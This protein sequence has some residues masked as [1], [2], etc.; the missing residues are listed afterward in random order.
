MADASA[1]LGARGQARRGALS[2]ALV[3]V[4]AAPPP[5]PWLVADARLAE[6]P[7]PTIELEDGTARMLSL[8]DCPPA[9]LFGRALESVVPTDERSVVALAGRLGVLFRPRDAFD[10][11][12]VR[13]ADSARLAWQLQAAFGLA[14]A[15]AFFAQEGAAASEL[16]DYVRSRPWGMGPGPIPFVGLL[17]WSSSA[18]RMRRAANKSLRFVAELSLECQES[19]SG[20]LAEAMCSEFL[21]AWADLAL[22]RRCPT[23]GIVFKGRSHHGATRRSSPALYCSEPC[24]RAAGRRRRLS[25]R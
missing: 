7:E 6:D 18:E 23:C 4:G 24:R 5:R 8:A 11:G 15:Y 17:G 9:E 16:I 10:D 13:V 14:S 1:C 22:W 19:R 2:L 20:S 25:G 21:A 3:P 12:S